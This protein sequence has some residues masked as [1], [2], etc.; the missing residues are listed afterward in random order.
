LNGSAGF[1]MTN[2]ASANPR[3]MNFAVSQCA[4]ST[5]HRHKGRA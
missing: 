5:P 1:R 3:K 2:S 4:E